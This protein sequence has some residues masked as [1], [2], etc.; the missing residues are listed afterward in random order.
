MVIYTL[1]LNLIHPGT[2]LPSDQNVYLDIDGKTER[3]GPGWIDRRSRWESFVD[4][5]DIKGRMKGTPTHEIFWLEPHRWPRVV[6]Q[7]V[8]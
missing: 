3:I 2:L 6:G 5:F 4:P 1:W 7:Q 8:A